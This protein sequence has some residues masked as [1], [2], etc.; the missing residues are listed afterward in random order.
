MKLNIDEI[1]RDLKESEKTASAEKSLMDLLLDE[2]T[3][4]VATAVNAEPAPVVAEPAPVVEKVAEAA[5][6]PLTEDELYDAVMALPDTQVKLA[7]AEMQARMF[8]RAYYDELQ[9]TGIFGATNYPMPSEGST[10][11]AIMQ[12]F[13]YGPGA[14]AAQEKQASAVD[15]E[16]V[17]I[18]AQLRARFS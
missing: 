9:A 11:E 12:P 17:D 8:A 1:L 15:A 5:P 3:E 14:P 4:K 2:P 7:Q 18:I 6:A 10:G 13:P 16:A